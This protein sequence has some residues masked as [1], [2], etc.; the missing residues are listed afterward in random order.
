MGEEAKYS[1]WFDMAVCFKCLIDNG[2]KEGVSNR[3]NTGSLAADKDY[4]SP[5]V[6]PALSARA[7]TRSVRRAH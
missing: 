3:A 7:T 6:R 5:P 1:C 2:G 4:D